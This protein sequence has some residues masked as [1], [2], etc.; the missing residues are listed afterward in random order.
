MGL[1]PGCGCHTTKY[2][3]SVMTVR[4]NEDLLAQIKAAA[5]QGWL[6]ED[7]AIVETL[8]A[9]KRAGASGIITYFAERAA[10]L[11]GK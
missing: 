2:M 9:F 6:D 4:L 8:S 1:L 10:Q 5:A 11:L 3:S 7:K